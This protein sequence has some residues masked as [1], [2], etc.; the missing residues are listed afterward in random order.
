MSSLRVIGRYEVKSKIARGGMA[1]VYHAYDP[2][3]ER[4]VAIKVLPEAF[5]H[6][7]QFRVRFEREAKMIALL[8]HPAIVPVYDFGEHEGM[9]YIVMRYMSGGSL[10]ERLQ[11][12]PMTLSE[13]AQMVFRMA[14]ALDAAHARNI[15][16]RDM[17]PG[18]VLF[19]QYGNAYLS[20]FGIAR[21]AETGSA[22]LTG[23]SILGTPA[24]MS[25]EQVQ[26]DK[27]IDG[28]S[29]LYSFGVMIFQ[30]LTGQIP[31]QADTPAKIMMMHVL[32]PAPSILK[33]RPDM[34][35]ELELFIQKTMAK[36]PD[37]RYPT[38]TE[39]SAGLEAVLHGNSGAGG[40]VLAAGAGA[41]SGP[42][43]VQDAANRP[44]FQ[45]PTSATPGETRIAGGNLQT[46]VSTAAVAN[47]GKPAPAA[48]GAAAPGG[49]AGTAAAAPRRS[50]GA[51][52]LIAIGL[53]VILLLAAGG[54]LALMGLRGSGPLAMLGPSPTQPPT[55][56][57]EPVTNT[58]VMQPVSI[59]EA[60]VA[61]LPPTNTSPP[62][63]TDTPA[64]TIPAATDTPSASETPTQLPG[65]PVMGGS[66]KMA[67]L[68]GPEIWVSDL[69]G[70][71]AE[72]LTSDKTSKA[73]LQWAPD[74][75]SVNYITGN[76]V[77]TVNLADKRT[78]LV[79]CFNFPAKFMDFEISPDG[80][81][82]AVVIDQE[83]F[84]LPYDL[85]ILQ[86]IKVRRDLS[87]KGI[88]Q[89]FEKN[90]PPYLVETIQWGKDGK[91]VAMII[92]GND[93]NGSADLI[94]VSTLDF[95]KCTA[96]QVGT[97]FPFPA[98]IPVEYALSANL[99]NFGWNGLTV[100]GFNTW[101]QGPGFGK[102]YFYDQTTQR[103]TK[104]VDVVGKCCYR[105]PVFTNDGS[106]IV[107]AYQKTARE[108]IQ[109]YLVD[110]GTIGT[111][112]TYTPLN[113]PPI[114]PKTPIEILLRPVQ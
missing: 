26:G 86:S 67:Y 2:R 11:P 28:R 96:T 107:L 34:P 92:K 44:D 85:S 4:D 90:F 24:Y 88:C 29:D 18:N 97:T 6:D 78:G 71:N 5:L 14:P 47:R 75:Q 7:P 103:A 59:T 87:T 9:P 36:N 55:P 33:V 112:M 111:G 32:Q 58:P 109:L 79:T 61:T 100:F 25:P 110:Y 16:H 15:I 54:G 52:V 72:Q 84:I 77:N 95:D 37:D 30:M 56:T 76:C 21:L 80:K 41:G 64:P 62:P 31:Y 108:P 93:S 45:M 89:Q 81:M 68:N 60:T 3:F 94:Q 19:D 46:V 12:G 102:L 43:M 69:D 65:G 50:S 27:S 70:S 82:V 63:A 74:G 38:A 49:G 114:D 53:V 35:A 91:T 99:T 22:T 39:L 48:A 105:N 104:E 42:T 66:D 40:A 10:T 20:D 51:G 13:T 101:M 106:Q 8:E 17:K 113:L 1:T 57:L 98:F 23:E 73:N 83:Y